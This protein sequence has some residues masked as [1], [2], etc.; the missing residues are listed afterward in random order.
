MPWGPRSRRCGRIFRVYEKVP[1]A[2]NV[3]SDHS[4]LIPRRASQAKP[5]RP[6]C[7]A[8]LIQDMQLKQ[9]PVRTTLSAHVRTLPAS[10]LEDGKC[11]LL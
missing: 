3:P 5:A 9:R 7:Q 6:N 4:I 1:P 11:C 8:A 10:L 2:R